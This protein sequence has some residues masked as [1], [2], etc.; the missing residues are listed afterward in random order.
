[1]WR[2]K[3]LA[4]IFGHNDNI[5]DRKIH[6]KQKQINMTFFL[7]FSWPKQKEEAKWIPLESSWTALAIFFLFV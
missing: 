1:M 5:I 2:A 7:P 3:S 4:K 6:L